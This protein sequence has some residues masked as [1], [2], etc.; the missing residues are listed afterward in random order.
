[1]ITYRVGTSHGEFV[2]E[3]SRDGGQG[4]F[5]PGQEP[6]NRATIDEA[7][8]LPGTPRKVLADRAE[9]EADVQLVSHACQE[10]VVQVVVGVRGACI[11]TRCMP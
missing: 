10:E 5:W 3:F 1:M 7:W 6:V 11:V 4:L 2:D 9:A 8:E